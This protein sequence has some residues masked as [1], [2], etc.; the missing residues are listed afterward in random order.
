MNKL[1]P[2]PKELQTVIGNEKIDF[3][4][5]ARRTRPKSQAYGTIRFSAIWLSFVCLGT[6]AFFSPVFKGEDVNFIVNDVPTTASWDNLEPLLIPSLFFLSLLSAG[7]GFLV[8][9]IITLRKEGGYFVGTENRL[10]NYKNGTIKYYDWEQFT[11][12]VELN[13]KNKDISLEMRKGF[14]RKRE[15]GP[16]G[17]I[18]DSLY[19]S[20]IEN[21]IE[22]ERICR[23]R[24]KEN[25]P[26]PALRR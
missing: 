23:E 17:V 1:A 9:G 3:S 16:D 4:V 5:Y 12:N 20:D 7:I 10:I 25:D 19:L 15:N 21:L 14:V 24:I 22:V 2:L 26:T 6:Y 11:G 13:F 18:P 8:S